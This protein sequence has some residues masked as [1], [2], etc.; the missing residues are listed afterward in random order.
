L[1][2]EFYDKSFSTVFPENLGMCGRCC[3]AL[4]A[5]EMGHQRRFGAVGAM[6]VLH[7]IADI[8]ARIA[9]FRSILSG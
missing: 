9:T 3:D 2:S 5:S 1:R 8:L 4:P 6:S 7:P